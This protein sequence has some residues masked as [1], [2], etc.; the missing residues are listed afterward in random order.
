MGKPSSLE[1][2]LPSGRGGCGEAAIRGEKKFVFRQER[3]KGP[4][5]TRISKLQGR[6]QGNGPSYPGVSRRE[7]GR[8]CDSRNGNANKRGP[9][10]LWREEGNSTSIE[11]AVNSTSGEKKANERSIFVGVQA[12]RTPAFQ[13]RGCKKK[14]ST[15]H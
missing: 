11:G 5:I 13:G 15:R 4:V 14:A 6:S 3:A 12:P 10:I 9:D 1:T 8:N 7:G 2:L